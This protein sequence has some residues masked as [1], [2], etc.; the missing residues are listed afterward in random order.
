MRNRQDWPSSLRRPESRRK[1][2][3]LSG[4]ANQL[5]DEIARL[6]VVALMPEK[7]DIHQIKAFQVGSGQLAEHS[8]CFFRGKPAGMTSDAAPVFACDQSLQTYQKDDLQS[9]QH[10]KYPAITVH[11]GQQ[12]SG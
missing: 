5:Y 7:A 12:E 8:A 2:G 4:P 9:D 11:T 3:L 10:Q 1:G 6:S